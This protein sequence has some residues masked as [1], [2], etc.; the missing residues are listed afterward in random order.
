[1]S[2]AASNASAQ[3]SIKLLGKVNLMPAIGGRQPMTLTY[4]D[5]SGETKTILLFSGELTAASLAGFLTQFGALQTAMDAVTLGTRSSQ[6]WGEKTV[7]S[8]TRPTDKNAQIESEL[9]VRVQGAVTEA[10]WSFRIPTVDYTAFNYAD[11]PAGDQVIISGAGASAATTALI[12]A[13]EA[14]A[15]MPDDETEAVNIVGM[16][17]VR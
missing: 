11:P 9:L 12:T 17:V 7:V 13:L 1:L 15:K 4:L 16:E 3:S 2:Y 5:Y 8:N 10:P 6:Q 14:V